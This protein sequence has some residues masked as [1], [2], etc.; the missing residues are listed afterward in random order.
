MEHSSY[1]LLQEYSNQV[2][3]RD[4]YADSASRDNKG[5]PRP[6]LDTSPT[7]V[8]LY[9]HHHY[10]PNSHAHNRAS[11]R[12]G[13]IAN[14]W[15]Y[16]NDDTMMVSNRFNPRIFFLLCTST[17]KVLHCSPY[18]FIQQH[19]FRDYNMNSKFPSTM[20]CYLKMCVND[21]S[22]TQRLC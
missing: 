2:E 18:L 17:F 15:V 6:G 4:K 9:L 13:I 14:S 20:L 12:I 7:L 3:I 1:K 5:Q 10:R 8:S 22:I 16:S 11:E 19:S 21:I